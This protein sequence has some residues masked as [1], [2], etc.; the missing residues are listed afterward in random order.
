MT[1]V[2]LFGEANSGARVYRCRQGTCSF[3]TDAGG[4]VAA[5]M[6]REHPGA[7]GRK[8]AEASR[9]EVEAVFDSGPAVP[10]KPV[11]AKPASKPASKP[12]GRRVT[13]R[14]E[15]DE[16]EAGAI[17]EAGLDM[18]AGQFAAMLEGLAKSRDSWRDR[19]QKYEAEVI[20]L[21]KIIDG[22]EKA[23]ARQGKART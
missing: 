6:R 14:R 23:L 21:R 10:P 20:E 22:V 2:P 12:K 18:F 4:K 11:E 13:V 1:V 15:A 8:A 7:R 19:A 17:S 5:H 16:V 3:T 9:R